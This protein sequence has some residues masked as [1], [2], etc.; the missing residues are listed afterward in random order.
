MSYRE[1]VAQHSDLN[2]DGQE[3]RFDDFEKIGLDNE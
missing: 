1:Y 2:W 3:D